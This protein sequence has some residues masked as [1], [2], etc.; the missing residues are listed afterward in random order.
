LGATKPRW[1]SG[2]TSL[3]QVVQLSFVTGCSVICVNFVAPAFLFGV[4]GS[5]A[6]RYENRSRMFFIERK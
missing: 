1:L 4:A 3:A 5:L 6:H 2:K